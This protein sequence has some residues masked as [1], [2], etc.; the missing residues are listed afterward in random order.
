MEKKFRFR[1][2]HAPVVA[3]EPRVLLDVHLDTNEDCASLVVQRK[4]FGS[5]YIVKLWA[6]GR[7]HRV[8]H[9]SSCLGLPLDSQGRVLLDEEPAVSDTTAELAL[10]R[11]FVTGLTQD[12][13]AL[14]AKG[15]G[16]PLEWGM[17]TVAEQYCLVAAAVLKKI[18]QMHKDAPA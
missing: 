4:G 9:V 11:E 12:G 13:I 6:D 15:I 16:A 3:P 10:L 7:L 2:V 8:V 1:A 18:Q 17:G 14:F 5:Y